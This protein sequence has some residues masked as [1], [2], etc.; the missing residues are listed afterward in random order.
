MPTPR[1]FVKHD[2][3]QCQHGQLARQCGYCERDAL[4][5]AL[6]AEIDRLTQRNDELRTANGFADL[7]AEIERLR[8]ENKRLRQSLRDIAHQGSIQQFV[9]QIDAVLETDA[10]AKE[11]V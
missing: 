6:R 4:I 10:A 9:K 2:L 3:T 5:A 11:D 7:E 8:A 1:D